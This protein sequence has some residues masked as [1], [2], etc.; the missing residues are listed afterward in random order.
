MKQLVCPI[1]TE[2]INEKITRIS[3]FIGILLIISGFVF[4]STLLFIILLVDYFIRAFTKIK[5]SPISYASRS[6]A[7]ALNLK[8]KIIGK[9]SKIFA[10]RLGFVIVL[11]ILLLFIFNQQVAALIFAG[12][13]VFFAMLEFALAVCIGCILYTYVVFPFYKK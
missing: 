2:R 3:A 1:S 4:N 13:Y 6:I 12:V 8:E 9:A 5:F 11:A 7:N 10:A